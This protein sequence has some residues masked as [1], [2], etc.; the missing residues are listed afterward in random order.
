MLTV[1]RRGQKQDQSYEMID[2][3]N[4][5]YQGDR[6]VGV[7]DDVNK[8]SGYDFCDNGNKF[9]VYNKDSWEY[10]YDG[11]GNMTSDPNKGI[12][13][14]TCNFL[15][16]PKWIT[17][18]NNQQINYLYLSTGEKLME[19]VYNNG[20]LVSATNYMDGFVY[21]NGALSYII[22]DEGRR[23]NKS[24]TFT[25][26]YVIKDHLGNTRVCFADPVCY[27]S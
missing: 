13:S 5:G 7:D 16:L 24:G 18:S 25:Y 26:E 17:L 10:T 6:L 4:Y 19:N 21:I 11:N 15:N 12:V 9:D 2:D 22:G 23:V 8:N 1:S 27:L 3:L 14:I 20:S